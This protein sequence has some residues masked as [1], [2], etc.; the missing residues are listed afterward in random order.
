MWCLVTGSCRACVI[1]RG[2]DLNKLFVEAERRGNLPIGI[3]LNLHRNTGL[4]SLWSKCLI[5]MF[6]IRR[7]GAVQG[8]ADNP[9]TYSELDLVWSSK[10]ITCWLMEMSDSG[11]QTVKP[12][13]HISC[14]ATTYTA[15]SIH[16]K[17]R[18]F[19]LNFKAFIWTI[20]TCHW[21][22]KIS[23]KNLCSIFKN[24]LTSKV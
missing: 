21:A 23:K 9:V 4:M 14:V 3:K 1:W 10:Y 11:T 15:T 8:L 7:V 16:G 2:R 20:F 6:V 12:I 17:P 19:G 22:E 13:T 5:W 24:R 18:R